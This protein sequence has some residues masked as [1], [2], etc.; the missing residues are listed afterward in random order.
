MFVINN[1]YV[2][3]DISGSCGA[4]F[5]C[6]GK[7]IRLEI[8]IFKRDYITQFPCKYLQLLFIFS[9]LQLCHI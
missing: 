6:Q 2:S 5:R 1:T 3:E 8:S 4:A 9:L 7:T